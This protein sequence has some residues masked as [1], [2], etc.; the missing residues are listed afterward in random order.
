M[1]KNNKVQVC[2]K[3]NP[4]C[5]K[6]LASHRTSVMWLLLSKLVGFCLSLSLCRNICYRA[7]LLFCVKYLIEKKL[8][9]PVCVQNLPFIKIPAV[10]NHIFI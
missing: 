5:P 1:E 6:P 3:R 7:V 8:H 4:F 10:S 2:C 9:G